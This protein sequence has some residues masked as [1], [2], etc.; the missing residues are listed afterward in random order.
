MFGMIVDK[1]VCMYICMY[2]FGVMI[3][4]VF[5]WYLTMHIHQQLGS[6]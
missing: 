5:A 2:V 1:Y 4:S 3:S 6:M